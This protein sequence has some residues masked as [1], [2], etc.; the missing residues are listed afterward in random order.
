[1]RVIHAAQ[2][3]LVAA[4]CCGQAG[5]P[6]QLSSPTPPQSLNQ[7][8]A[9][10]TPANAST[11][12]TRKS[13]A[14]IASSPDTKT[15]FSTRVNLVVVPVVVRDRKN[16]AIGTLTKEDFQLFDKGKLQTIT[17]FSV[18]KA[19]EKAASEAAQIE[20]GA[21]QP[22]A[23]SAGGS[24]AI[25]TRFVA[26]LFD[27][28]HIDN[29]DLA[30]VR[31]ATI[32]HL[33]ETLQP[34]DR[35][36]IYTTS[37]IGNLDFT[38]D[39]E[40]MI[41]TLNRIASRSRLS[42][43]T[44]C[45]PMNFYEADLITNRNDTD[46]LGVAT[47]DAL[48]CA[49]LLDPQMISRGASSTA[50]AA[51]PQDM[52]SAR[53]LAQGAASRAVAIGE[54]EIQQTLG[55]LTDVVRRMTSIP[56]Q[57]SV[58]LISP[59]FQITIN[60]LQE[61][62][63]L[64]DRAIR[65][66]VTISSLDARGLYAFDTGVE[67]NQPGG[68]NQTKKSMYQHM[69]MLADSDVLAE[70]SEGTGG[71][72]FHDNNDY[73]EGLRL[74]AAAPEFIYLL[75]FSPQNLK[76]DGSFHNVKV[77]LK[78]KDLDMQARRG[79][80]APKHAINEAEQAKQEIREAMFSREEVQ[81]F[82]VALQTQFFKTTADNARL[83]VLAHIDM[84]NLKF[85]KAE[86][87]DTNTLTI[88]SGLFDRNGNLLNSIQKTVEMRLKEETFDA[89]LAAGLN[90]K[91]SFDVQPGKYVLRLVVRDSEGQMMSAR[92]GIVDIP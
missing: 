35:A 70:V 32:K 60:Y 34:T 76:Y 19:G 83:S 40:K 87:R 82:P 23:G 79:Y 72:F 2:C 77:V 39:R 31:A 11:G 26:Y 9:G 25:P 13:T 89:K 80:Y 62:M 1:M 69:S 44:D 58:V 22:G 30:Q 73:K 53:G 41:D 24:A 36:A 28:L 92:N 64:L 46:A 81:E 61:E 67:L 84:K 65:A 7:A 54:A 14:E 56:G 21:E 8:P 55:S 42:G 10:A 75:G 48:I 90:V 20:A 85:Q 27:D 38:D 37:G 6:A 18:E 47:N 57:R 45:P 86:G 17:R 91:T 68:S 16:H 78:P 50:P 59:G 5:S 63:E 15:T 12:N 29:G 4:A 52:Q 51:T 49:S 3:F 33:T 74:T 88:V 71:T 43:T 66:K